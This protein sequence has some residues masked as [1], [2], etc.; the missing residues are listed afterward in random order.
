MKGCLFFDVDGT[1]VNSAIGEIVPNENVMNAIHQAQE[2]GY[3]CFISTGRNLG[4]ISELRDLGFDGYVF[5]DGGGIKL[6]GKDSILTPI[7]E[8]VLK[9]WYDQVVKYKAEVI[10]SCEHMLFATQGQYQEIL[11]TVHKAHME[12]GVNEQELLNAWNM[13][14]VKEYDGSPI[15]ACDMSFENED[16]ENQW[17][18]E[19]SPE[20]DYVCTSA[21]YGRG[22]ATTGELTYQGVNKGVGC[23][24]MTKL[25]G[26][27]LNNTYAF[28]DSMND[29]S[30]FK[31]CTH[32]IAMGN[33]AEE[34]KNMAEYITDDINH[35]GIVS[36]L[37]YFGIIE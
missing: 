27:D 34:L 35:D 16:I 12:S 14:P 1:L 32:S 37:K 29:A 13:K 33:A 3:L 9:E 23:I 36:A 20:L 7:P 10:L 21:S 26:C 28:G 15:I 19:K 22:G 24:N 11:D 2:N 5:S 25:C 4:G 31:T 6:E 30:M 8:S 17:L 18:K